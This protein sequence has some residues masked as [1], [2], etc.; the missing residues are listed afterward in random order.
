VLIDATGNFTVSL[1]V[2]NDV[3]EGECCSDC[4]LDVDVIPAPD[5][6]IIGPYEVCEDDADD[7]YFESEYSADTY[8]WSVTGD[9]VIDGDN[10]LSDVYVDATGD[11]TVHLEV[12]DI[13]GDVPCCDDCELPVVVIPVPDCTID[14]PET[15][16]EGETGIEYCSNDTADS[17]LWTISGDGSI[18]GPDDEQCVTVDAGTEGSFTLT[19]EVCNEGNPEPIECCDD[20]DIDVDVVPC[21]AYCSFT[22]GF[23]GN[24]NGR[25]CDGSTTAELLADLI[26]PAL[27]VGDCGNTLTFETA[28]DVLDGL[29]AGGPAKALDGAETYSAYTGKMHKDGRIKNVLVGQVVALTLNIRLGDGCMMDTQ[30]LDTLVLTEGTFCTIPYGGD[31]E[32]VECPGYTVPEEFDGMTVGELLDAANRALG[33]CPDAED[34]SIGA[35]ND[36]IDKINNAFDECREIVD[37]PE[38]ICDNDIDD[39]CDG[40][41]D[42]A[43]PDC[44]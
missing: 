43:D 1:E 18:V 38:E 16:C 39:D 12:C 23:W 11:F 3:D 42:E 21:G 32:D 37:C 28:Q 5:C 10:D 8:L 44:D 19:L 15:V 24:A 13:I 35:I 25:A 27:V 30:P 33:D 14:G 6:G 41:V 9:A 4:D 40:L 2:C 20:C 26:P 22:Q 17:Y 31:P 29:P 34:P 7:L 36:M